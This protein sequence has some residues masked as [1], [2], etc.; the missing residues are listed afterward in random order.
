MSVEFTFAACLIAGGSG[1]P[2]LLFS[3]RSPLGQMIAVL[4]MAVGCAIGLTHALRVLIGGATSSIMVPGV[5]PD[6][7]FHLKIDPL[8]AFFQVPIFL[9]GAVGSIYG[10][11]YWRQAEHPRNGRKLSLCYGLLIGGLGL[12]TLAGDSIAFLFAWE[13]MALAAFFLV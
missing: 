4:S 2:G 10:L 8:A 9:L 1:L 3:R 7:T 11:R 13:I 6:W 5:L 12:V